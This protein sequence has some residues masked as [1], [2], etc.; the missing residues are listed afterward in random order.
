MV[1]VMDTRKSK[2][3][4]G[5]IV[6]I[7][8]E[9]LENL[10]VG[11]RVTAEINW[12]KRYRYMRM[13]TCMHVFCS[14]LEFPVTGGNIS[15]D[16]CR[17]DFD[18]PEKPDKQQLTDQLNQLISRNT[19]LGTRWI[20]D[21]EMQANMDLV[22]TMSVKPPMGAGKV[23]LVEIPGID[24]QPCGGTHVKNTSEIGEVRVKKI[25]NKGKQN[26]RVIIELVE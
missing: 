3:Q 2:Q 7:V 9:G 12:D 18:M 6:H 4:P 13:H 23:R 17:L 20:S 15:L 1:Q 16:K 11:D 10:S 14:I 24:L 19:E 26:K 8:N 21:E 5:E 25:E 22:K